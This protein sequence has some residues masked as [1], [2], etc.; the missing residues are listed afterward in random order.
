MKHIN[1]E[2]I[3]LYILDT[4]KSLKNKGF[5]AYIVG[6]CVRDLLLEKDPK[7]WDITTNANPDQI[8]NCFSKTVY[9]NSFGTVAVV[10][11]NNEE[12]S[13]YFSIS[14]DKNIIIEITPYRTEGAYSDG[15]HPDRIVFGSSLEE[16]LQRRDFTINAIAYDP[17]NDILKDIFGGVND[18]DKKIIKTVGEATDRFKEDS[19]RV[20]RAIRLA[21]QLNFTVSHETLEGIIS[22]KNGLSRVSNER[23][24]D[25]FIKIVESPNPAFAIGFMQKTDIL[26]YICPEIEEGINCR[27]GGA[28]KYDVFDHLV[29]ALQH[30]AD[31]NWPLDI[32]LSALFHD[33]G[34]PRTKREY[35]DNR[36]PTFYG[37]E[38]VGS[39]MTKKILENLKFSRETID[40]VVKMVRY[41][42]FFSDTEQITLS[43][44]RR[45]VSNVGPENIWDLM[46]VRECDR[47]G[48]SKTEAPYRLRKYHAMIEEVLRDPI[49]VKQLKING[50]YMIKELHVKP[51]K[52]MGW[53]LHA[54]L[55][56]V[57]EDPAKNDIDYLVKRIKDMEN[58]N[59]TE[60]KALGESGKNKMDELEEIEREELN[61]KYRVDK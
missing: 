51:G 24:R 47:V 27:Q 15:R 12:N 52:R 11:E 13:R 49:S 35:G 48:M 44:V 56:E 57:L 39:K 2:N 14:E 23:I 22:A 29:Q 30:A 1:K 19:L 6:G 58:L 32:R 20:L 40:K 54:L 10:I 5:E 37:H 25:E 59:D 42:M 46:K 45:M 7:D 9:E 31:K 26:K 50:D 16:D 28:H 36:K 41:H 60:L 3:P 21:V 17:I 34:K 55:E 43:A 61:K 4:L 53:I 8:Q 38:V 33:I 18:I